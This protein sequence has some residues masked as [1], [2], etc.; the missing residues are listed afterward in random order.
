MFLGT[1]ALG[2]VYL[3]LNSALDNVFGSGNVH[4]DE[5]APDQ[6]VNTV[7]VASGASVVNALIV[8]LV[9]CVLFMA[10]T[11]KIFNKRDIK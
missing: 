8:G 2:L 1:G 6:L 9:C 10:L 5:G 11:I 4:I 3:G 7:N